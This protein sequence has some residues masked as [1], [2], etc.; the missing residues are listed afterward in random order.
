M[1]ADIFGSQPA[2]ADKLAELYDLEHDEVVDDLPFYRELARRISG[3]VLDLGCGSGRL[4]RTL[5]EGGAPRILGLDGS[6]ALV[7]RA[8]AR[9]G[10]DDLLAEAA[11]D[12]RLSVMRG[13]VRAIS[14]LNIRERFDLALAVGVLP[15]LDGPEDALR[16]LGGAR[17]VLAKGGRLVLDDL[18]PGE[19]PD[20]DMPLSIDWK[21]SLDGR[22]V[23]RR[24]ELVRRETPEGLRVAFSTIADAVQPDGTI[25]RLPASHEL[26]YPSP[27]ALAALVR[28]AGMVVELSYGSH[29]LEPLGRESERRIYVVAYAPATTPSHEVRV[30]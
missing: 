6:P 2:D 4:F 8:E 19:M 1:S 22:E 16:L 17:S 11:R 24:S 15:H 3:P 26:W 30:G 18:G 28:Q 27:E 5:L 29:D 20:R 23:V 13:D 21:R 12:G 9:I 14:T 7:R 10:R 25:A